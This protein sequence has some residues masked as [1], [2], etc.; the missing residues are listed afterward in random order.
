MTRNGGEDGTLKE[1]KEDKIMEE[2]RK[3]RRNEEVKIT[4]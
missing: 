2:K 1:R 3:K 4:K